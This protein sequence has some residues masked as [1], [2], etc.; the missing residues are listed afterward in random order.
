MT[1]NGNS[2]GRAGMKTK[3]NEYKL[4]A[5]LLTVSEVTRF[6]GVHSSTVKRWEKE[7]LL[8]SYAIGLHSNLGFREE[9]ILKCV[10]LSK[11]FKQDVINFLQQGT[12]GVSLSS[13]L[14]IKR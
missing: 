8:K 13:D 11:R 6:L 9:D 4:P 10:V 3:Y 2:N 1:I 12:H 14:D 5:K 7:G